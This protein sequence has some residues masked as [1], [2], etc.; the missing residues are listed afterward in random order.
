MAF[1]SFKEEVAG[2]VFP[3]DRHSFHIDE[4]ELEKIK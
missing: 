1:Q 4:K 2:G 3:T